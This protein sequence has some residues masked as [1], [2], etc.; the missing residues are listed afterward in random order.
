MDSFT[1]NQSMNKY[2][3]V[4]VLYM[5]MHVCVCNVCLYLYLHICSRVAIRFRMCQLVHRSLYI[6]ASDFVTPKFNVSIL[7]RPDLSVAYPRDVFTRT[8]PVKFLSDLCASTDRVWVHPQTPIRAKFL[9]RI[10]I[11]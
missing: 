11:L 4:Y 7:V 3:C 10:Q 8:R 9:A 5:C 2:A 6:F 1:E